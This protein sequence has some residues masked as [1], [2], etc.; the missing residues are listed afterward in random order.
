[1]LIRFALHPEVLPVDPERIKG[2]M[3]EIAA[4][5]QQIPEVLPALALECHDFAVQDAGASSPAKGTGFGSPSVT[6]VTY[7]PPARF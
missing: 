2:C 1:M 5:G 6:S 3:V 7:Q 4:P